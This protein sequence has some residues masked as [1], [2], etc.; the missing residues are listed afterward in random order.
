MNPLR[1]DA[2]MDLAFSKQQNTGI[3]FDA[4]DDIPVETSGNNVPSTVNTFAEIDFGNVLNE[5]IRRCKYM[6]PTPI[7]HYAIP[8]SLVG[9]Y[10]MVC[11]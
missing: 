7:Q 9:R 4:Y 6:K 1:D 11:A 2:A 10:L 8:I 3:N 5:N